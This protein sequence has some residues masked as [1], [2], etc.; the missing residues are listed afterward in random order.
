MTLL[1]IALACAL[2]LVPDCCLR[3][4]HGLGM[5]SYGAICRAAR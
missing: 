1:P 2:L 4:H 3:G 5:E